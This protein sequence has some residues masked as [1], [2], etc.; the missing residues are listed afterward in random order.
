MHV[1]RIQ[2]TIVGVGHK[3]CERA[4]SA[5]YIK[6]FLQGRSSDSEV[7]FQIGRNNTS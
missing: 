1:H 3:G 5:A 6:C 7:G 4:Q 2:E